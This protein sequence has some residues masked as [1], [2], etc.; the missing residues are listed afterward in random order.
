[1]I[2]NIYTIGHSNIELPMFFNLLNKY[3]IEL[4][5]DVRSNP[6]SKFVPDYNKH[7]I[8]VSC[9]ERGIKYLFLGNLLGG[10]PDDDSVMD[11]EKNVDYFL[12]EKKDYY[13]SGIDSLVKLLKEYQVC[14]MCSEGEP[15]KCH[16]SLLISPTLEKMGIKVF[17]ILPDGSIIDSEELKLKINHGQLSLF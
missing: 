7:S 3:N 6:Y 5:V 4:L 1:M 10:K 9:E 13:L 14:I 8:K 2:S 15:D 17:H 16:R 11:K 12:L